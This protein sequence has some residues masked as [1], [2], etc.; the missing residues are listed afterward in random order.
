[1]SVRR[2]WNGSK[3]V[4][5]R[6]RFWNGSKWVLSGDRPPVVI[7][8]VTG[9]PKLIED[10]LAP[11]NYATVITVGSGGYATV[12]SA[13]AAAYA[14]PGTAPVLVMIPPGRYTESVIT[15]PGHARYVDIRS[16]TLN[17]NDVIID[18]GTGAVDDA[19]DHAGSG[20]IFAGL[21]LI[22]RNGFSAIH[23]GLPSNSA[24]QRD[25]IYYKINGRNIGGNVPFS[26]GLGAGFHVYVY[27]CTFE[28]DASISPFGAG[29]VYAH[30][31]TDTTMKARFVMDDVRLAGLTQGAIVAIADWNSGHPD[32]LWVRNVQAGQRPIAVGYKPNSPT[33]GSMT[34]VVQ[35]GIPVDIAAGIAVT[36][37]TLPPPFTPIRL[38]GA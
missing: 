13:V 12:S 10:A 26:W 27:D 11:G 35:A 1:M 7:G 28:G 34:G 8:P 37:G 17:P 20:G 33:V 6:S 32:Q 4:R 31:F 16:T 5:V 36:S 25:F 18:P 14:A 30:T 21:T 29:A 19:L 24:G 9:V 22:G 15:P 38:G 23:S 2:F 3:W